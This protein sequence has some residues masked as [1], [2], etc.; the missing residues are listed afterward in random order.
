MS[1]KNENEYRVQISGGARQAAVP[2][3]ATLLEAARAAGLD[4]AAEC[5]GRGTC[6]RCRVHVRGDV[7][8]P[9]EQEI[10]ALGAAALE[11]GERLACRARTAGDVSI[12]PLGP[13]VPSDVMPFEQPYSPV[14]ALDPPLKI[15]PLQLSEPSLMDARSDVRRALEAMPPDITP[16]LTLDAIR[17]LP[18]ILRGNNFQAAAYVEDSHVES[19]GPPLLQ[20]EPVPA[21]ALDIGTTTLCARL[22]DLNTG[23]T[24]AAAQAMNPQRLY[25]ADVAARIRFAAD[26]PHGLETLRVCVI[27]RANALIARL[28]ADADTSPERIRRLSLAGNPA[29]VHLLLGVDPR[30]IGASPY[31]PV[32]TTAYSVP[33]REAGLRAAPGAR[34]VCLPAAAAYVGGDA[35][36][37]LLHAGLHT[38]GPPRLVIDIG[39]NAEIAL[40]DGHTLYA[41]AAAAGPAFEGAHISCGMTAAPGAIDRVDIGDHVKVNTIAGAPPVGLCG[42]GLIDALAALLR[43]R[44]IAPNGRIGC[45]LPETTPQEIKSRLRKTDNIYDFILSENGRPVAL[46]QADVRQAQLARAAVRAGQEILLARAGVN[47][48]DLENIFIAGAFGAALR[49]ESALRI[50]LV[51]D[52]PPE[53]IKFI[54]NA[55]LNGATDA[56]LSNEFLKTAIQIT[57]KIKYIEL[58][59]ASEFQDLFLKYMTFPEL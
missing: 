24:L 49:P 8:P 22:V 39:T 57:D 56:L 55:A 37:A 6:G 52:V 51:P 10:K 12:T 30:G 38:P 7:S 34:V 50:G 48:N 54:G 43:A 23:R 21:A 36:A 31:T 19:V 40:T 41:C 27:D 33:A 20:D 58:S 15:I 1:Q 17:Q 42:A 16:Q 53:R 47:A 5:G 3:G 2:A 35:V 9:S 32:F 4:L 25:G 29:M 13:A 14:A 59:A 28:A 11:K 44:I 26:N 46:T 18:G 45:D